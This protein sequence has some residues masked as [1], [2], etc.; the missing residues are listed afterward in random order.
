M[1]VGTLSLV[2]KCQTSGCGGHSAIMVY[3][4]GDNVFAAKSSN[5]WTQWN[6]GIWWWGHCLGIKRSNQWTQWMQLN[7]GIWWWGQCLCCKKA[8]LMDPV[9]VVE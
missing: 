6:H 5:Q 2:Q 1:V 7:S 9:D 8:K 4:G 3:G